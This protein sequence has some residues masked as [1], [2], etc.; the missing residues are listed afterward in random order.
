MASAP[1]SVV[2]DMQFQCQAIALAAEGDLPGH[3]GAQGDHGIA[4][5]D[6]LGQG[7][8]RVLHHVEQSLNE[9]RDRPGTQGWRCRSREPP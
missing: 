2:D 3:P 5:R 8:R 9:L 1:R 4:L 6:T 7:L